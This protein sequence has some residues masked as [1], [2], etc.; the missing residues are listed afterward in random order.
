[1]LWCQPE[2][3]PATLPKVPDRRRRAQATCQRGRRR[4]RH[5]SKVKCSQSQRAARPLAVRGHARREGTTAVGRQVRTDRVVLCCFAWAGPLVCT[6]SVN[7]PAINGATALL[8]AMVEYA[9]R[10]PA[11]ARRPADHVLCAHS[12][13]DGPVSSHFAQLRKETVESVTLRP[14]RGHSRARTSAPSARGLCLY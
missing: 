7:T 11:T 1:M 13:R 5:L 9:Q 12:Q 8:I 4:H 10:G 14:C 6:C 3:P 2:R